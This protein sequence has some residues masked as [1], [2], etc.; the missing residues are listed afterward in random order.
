MLD[1][2]TPARY[3]NEGKISLPVIDS[4]QH[5]SPYEKA[6]IVGIFKGR[7][8]SGLLPEIKASV[9]NMYMKEPLA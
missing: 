1:R 5:S 8:A 4:M 7:G 2:R 3:L 9:L 6:Q